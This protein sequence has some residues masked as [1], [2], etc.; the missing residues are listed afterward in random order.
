MQSSGPERKK[1]IGYKNKEPLARP[2]YKKRKN[3]NP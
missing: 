2:I 3:I 1:K